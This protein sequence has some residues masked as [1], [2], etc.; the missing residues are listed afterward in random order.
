MTKAEKPVGHLVPTA[1]IHTLDNTEGIDT[2]TPQVLL[3]FSQRNPYGRPGID[4]SATYPVISEPLYNQ[5]TLDRMQAII[6]KQAKA[7]ER[8]NLILT[9][10]MHEYDTSDIRKIISKALK[11]IPRNQ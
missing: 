7:L 10:H 4:Y 1:W 5:K 11:A 2:N 8:I 9:S 3:C 6:N